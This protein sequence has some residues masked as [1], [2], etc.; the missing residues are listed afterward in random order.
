MI[1]L[2]AGPAFHQYRYII[3]VV[4]YAARMA[5]HTAPLAVHRAVSWA[6]SSYAVAGS[7]SPLPWSLSGFGFSGRRTA[8][9]VQVSRRE[10][11]R[12]RGQLLLRW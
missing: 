6:K 10:G 1:P 3:Q 5:E 9:K 4:G 2:P 11:Y 7:D 8:M 12:R